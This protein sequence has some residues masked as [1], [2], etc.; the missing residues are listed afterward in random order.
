MREIKFRA[1]HPASNKYLVYD[2][3]IGSGNDG[4]ICKDSDGNLL[5]TGDLIW[6]QYTGSKDKN[7][8][9]IYEGDTVSVVD[10]HLK[11]FVGSVNYFNPTGPFY[12]KNVVPPFEAVDFSSV[13]SF[14]G[15]PV[16]LSSVCG[17]DCNPNIEVVGTIHDLEI[18]Q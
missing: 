13:C 14:E 10:G 15:N 2:W 7:G 3:E 12:L 1:W 8:V 9:E 18:N 4:Y 5:Y 16:Y 11:G 17:F 6:E